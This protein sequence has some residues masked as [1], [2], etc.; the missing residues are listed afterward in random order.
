MPSDVL[1]GLKL[2]FVIQRLVVAVTVEVLG[3]LA[4]SV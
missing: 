1:C 3:L 2:K 4:G